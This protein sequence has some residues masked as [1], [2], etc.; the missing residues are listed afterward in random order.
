M[1]G[2][3]T[4]SRTSK[5]KN[6]KDEGGKQKSTETGAGTAM[7]LASSIGLKIAELKGKFQAGSIPLATDFS[8]L[9]DVAD[10]GRR[11]T[12]QSPDQTDNN[13]GIGLKLSDDG[14]LLVK[15]NFGITVDSNG[16]SVNTSAF[17]LTGMI[18]MF[19]GSTT[20]PEGWALCNGDNETPDLRNR[21]IVGGDTDFMGGTNG[22]SFEG[23]KNSKSMSVKSDAGD[24][25]AK[26]TVGDTRLTIGQIPNH[27]HMVSCDTVAGAG[28][29]YSKTDF[30]VDHNSS[31]YI[32]PPL[33]SGWTDVGGK[34][35]AIGT[36][37]DMPHDHP[38]TVDP[39][40][41]EH[42]HSIDIS[43]PYYILAF[44][45]KL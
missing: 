40:S 20:I 36:G 30:V 21:F 31:G 11:A 5:N 34:F 27:T 26:V 18:M 28:V 12:G 22:G 15:G 8:S 16:V 35:Y 1:M 14:K 41:Q 37:G 19:H 6:I 39:A 45:M 42:T 13:V 17:F 3:N 33:I 23:D 9:I 24:L 25:D 2:E 29:Y 38:A 32:S 43:P 44:I 7:R 4:S 10:C